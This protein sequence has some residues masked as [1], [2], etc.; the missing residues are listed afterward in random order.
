VRTSFLSPCT[1]GVESAFLTS[2]TTLVRYSAGQLL[3][4]GRAR[5]KI[6]EGCLFRIRSC[7]ETTSCHPRASYAIRQGSRTGTN[8][9][10]NR[11]FYQ[12]LLREHQ[13][14][15]D[16]PTDY[17]SS[18]L[19]ARSG[20]EGPGQGTD[21]RPGLCAFRTAIDLVGHLRA[22]SAGPCSLQTLGRTRRSHA[23]SRSA[24]RRPRPASAGA[25]GRTRN[26]D[27]MTRGGF[28]RLYSDPVRAQVSGTKAGY[29][30]HVGSLERL[31]DQHDDEQR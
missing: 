28:K 26:G 31:G 8:G 23:R 13:Q 25:A 21:S 24:C 27:D 20:R 29:R 18:I 12:A 7:S 9:H 15:R 17:A 3:S 30:G 1:R 2:A 5:R 6:L 11:C 14:R 22:I 4:S 16:L 19:V 10:G